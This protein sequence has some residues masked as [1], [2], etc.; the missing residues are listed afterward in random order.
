LEIPNQSHAGIAVAFVG[1]VVPDEPRFQTAAFSQAGQMYQHELIVGLKNAGLPV[2]AI[3]S[4]VP[5]PSRRHPQAGRLWVG[6]ERATLPGGPPIDLIP[7]I[8]VTPL[9]QI[10]IGVGTILELLRWGWKNRHEHSRIVYCYN[11]SVPPGLFTL[12]GSR[13]I[14]AKKVVLLCDIDVPGET[15]PNSLYHRLDYWLQRRL[16]PRF[17]GHVVASDAIAH[18][19]LPGKPYLRLE[20]GLRKEI[21]EQTGKR[22][23]SWDDRNDVFV[24]ASAGRLDETNGI[25]QL[26]QAFSLLSGGKFQLRIAGWGPLEEQVRAASSRDARIKFLGLLPFAE[27]LEMY[28]SSDL[29]INLRV[30]QIR[31]TKYFFPSKMMEYLASGVPVISTCTGHVEE[32]FGSFTYLLREETP[33]ALYKLIRYVSELDPQERRESGRMARAYMAT[34]KTWEAQTQKLAAFFRSIVRPSC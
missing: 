24:I 7:F 27:V 33:E 6:S 13:L 23:A 28:D 9:K 3:I 11:L 34:H 15:A 26:L 31:N 29:L 20:G 21:F 10:A 30:T 18:D 16:I 1:S 32:E 14:R 17:D 4:V 25:P 12:I 8:N 2:S 19:F 5:V 22:T